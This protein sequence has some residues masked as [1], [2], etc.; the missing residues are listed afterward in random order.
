M[1]RARNI[2]GF[3]TITTTPSPVH[4]GPIGVL[5][6]TRID[7][8]FGVVDINP[9]HVNISGI[10]TGLNV[11]GIITAQNGIN[12]NGT[13]TGLNV[14]GIG[15]IAT[16]DVNGNADVSGNL[17]VG[18]VL[19]YEDVT[20][21]DSV[22]V[23]TARE[24]V[25]VGTG[26]SIAAGGLNVT[27]GVSTFGGAVT[28]NSTL[29][30]VGELSIS[31]TI[32]HSG[33]GNTKIRFPA[34]D[35]ITAETSGSERLRITSDGH[36]INQGLTSP[37]F[38][39]SSTKVLE[40]SGD[41][42]VGNSGVLNISGNVNSSAAVGSIR[43]N[44]RENTSSSSGSSANSINI[45]SI[46]VFADT[47]DSNAGDDCGGFMRFITKADGGG[48]AEAMR[49]DSS[50]RLL[51]GTTVTTDAPANDAGDI[52]IG[53]T[54][55][56]QK[57]ITIVGSTS[58]GINNIFFS[59]GA[60]YNNQGRIAY[61]HA[62]D[63]MRFTT[64]VAERMR[65][66]NSGQV[67]INKTTNRD[68]YY[69]GTL[70]GNLQVEGTDNATRLTQFIHNSNAAAQHILVIGKSRGTSAGSYTVVQNSDYLGTLSFQGA[71]GDAMIEGAR[72]DAIVTAAPGD[73]DMPTSLTFGTTADGAS[74]TTE[75]LRITNDGKFG[76]N[77]SNPAN[78]LVL[79]TTAAHTSMVIMSASESTQLSL[80]T[81]QDSDVRVGT[82]SNHP[83]TIYS[84]SLE[85]MRVDTYGVLRVGNTHT[86]TTSSNTKRIALGAKGSI[87][88]WATG[89]INGAINIAD[90]Y[91]WDGANNKAIE[92]D[93]CA[94][95][96]L[97]SGSLRFGATASTQTAGNSKRMV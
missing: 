61:Y 10:T 85:R 90:N 24:Q 11:S 64:N 14:S 60:G 68:Q 81:V 52:I 13:S 26:V 34:A 48:N 92:S 82:I 19:T 67:L 97:R 87:W 55:D 37:S 96:T 33:D 74:S 39:Y 57:G 38:L 8:A 30:V 1:T 59:D 31:D 63:S 70:T 25:H 9:R 73:Q 45:A 58:G 80:Q 4:V 22:G 23:I 32:V 77:K 50:G 95:L 54:S 66:N 6:A 62:D 21:I 53:T 12:F 91:Y 75:R 86:Q 72:I 42:T 20:R 43:F 3:S 41:G 79:K 49:I 35:T 71:D 56:T 94:F 2:A 17:N 15:T 28:A 69:G 44:N 47:S 78:D 51:I 29:Q 18:G 65:I 16:L 36:I 76:F 40:V 89:Q 88:G 93:H 27:A 7:G 5:T 83:L 84:N 46:D